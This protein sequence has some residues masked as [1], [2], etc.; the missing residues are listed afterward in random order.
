MKSWM[1]RASIAGK[2]ECWSSSPST[3]LRPECSR[4]HPPAR[5][6]TR[7]VRPRMAFTGAAATRRERGLRASL[8]LF[9]QHPHHRR[10]ALFALEVQNPPGQ[11]VCALEAEQGA[12]QSDEFF[13]QFLPGHGIFGCATGN[14]R[15][16]LEISLNSNLFPG[17]EGGTND[18][19]S[20]LRA[21]LLDHL[22]MRPGEKGK[23]AKE[24]VA[25]WSLVVPR[26]R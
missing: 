12:G 4:A 18:P 25:V 10:D 3:I 1:N 23:L 22:R 26:P 2:S 20:K 14:Q 7:A 16:E 13:D 24:I 21:R 17:R 15:I 6:R 9:P 5:S 19:P 8:L 11:F